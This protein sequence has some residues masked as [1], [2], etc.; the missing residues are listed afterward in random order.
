MQ[1]VSFL[2][3]LIAFPSVSRVSNVE[4]SRWAETQLKALGFQTEWLEYRDQ[5]GIT[6]ACVS[7]RLGP[8]NGRGMAYFCHTDVVPVTS[9]SFPKSGPWEPLQDDGKLYGRGS[10]DMKGS[11]ACM[12]AAVAAIDP[13][14]LTHPVYIV[15]TADEEVGLVG[16]AKMVEKSAMYR[17]IVERQ[18]RAIIGEP[19]LLNVVHAHKGGQGATVTAEG[20]AAHSSSDKGLNANFVMIPFLAELNE[21]REE[22]KGNPDFEDDRFTPP[23]ISMNIG[24]NDNNAALN[25]TAPKSVC[26]ICLRTMPGI[27]VDKIT[28]RLEAMAARH[29]VKLEWSYAT[30]P[31]FTDPESDFVQELLTVTGTKAS[32]TVAYGTDGSCFQELQDIVVLG[33]GDIRQAHTDDEWISLEQL[34]AGT[35]LYRTLAERWCCE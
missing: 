32:H 28:Q 26:T 21:F 11:L 1:S 14:K 5:Q 29:N 4:V 18:C 22:I 33:P 13:Q 6:K 15:C 24:I 23:T 3:E 9:W 10:C 19:T 8:D 25:I 30:K 12:L 31:L 16:A 34:Q 20:V 17:E 7:G 27:D 35:D 2:S